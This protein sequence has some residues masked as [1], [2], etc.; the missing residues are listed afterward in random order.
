MYAVRR[1][2]KGGGGRT[3]VMYFKRGGGRESLRK[4]PY[5]GLN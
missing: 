5:L 2:L 3:N 4:L 1:R